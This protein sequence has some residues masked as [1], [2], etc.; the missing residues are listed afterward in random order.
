MKLL[1]GVLLLLV[2]FAA[3]VLW[4]RSW[5]ATA[6]AKRDLAQQSDMRDSPAPTRAGNGDWGRVIVGR[7]SGADPVEPPT[8]ATPSATRTPSSDAPTPADRSGARATTAGPTHAP[9]DT[10]P[11]SSV[12]VQ[13]GDSLSSLCQAHYVTSRKE[14]V[15]ALAR[16]NKLK[17]AD[18]LREGATLLIPPLDRLTA[19]DR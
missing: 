5:L 9:A 11:A 3:A 1:V 12:I 16:Y 14:V 8:S 13:R 6:E 2:A 4:Q 18:Q 17:D 7:P 19:G 15:Q 10:G